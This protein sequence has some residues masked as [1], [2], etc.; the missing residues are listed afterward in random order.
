MRTEIASEGGLEFRP[1]FASFGARFLGLLVDTAVLALWMLPGIVLMVVGSTPLVIVGA[2]LMIAGFA[3]ATVRYAR[4]VASSGQSLGNRVMS[5]RVV[6][7][8]NGAYVSVGH[9][10]TRFV[11]R[12]LISTILFIGFLMAFANNQRRTFHDNVAGTVVTRPPR[13]TWSIDQD[14]PDTDR[15]PE[16]GPA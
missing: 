14:Q 11:I 5:T 6:D 10:G 15:A 16:S 13:A 3:I 2:G 7:A 1:A 4:T 9:A 12:Y 8:R